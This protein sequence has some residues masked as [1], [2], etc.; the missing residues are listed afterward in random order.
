MADGLE[1][2]AESDAV[3]AL[4][5][6][7]VQHMVTDTRDLAAAFTAAAAHVAAQMPHSTTQPAGAAAAAADEAAGGEADAQG[8]SEMP[9]QQLQQR[10]AAAGSEVDADCQLALSH[11]RDSYGKLL[12]V[13]LLASLHRAGRDGP[14]QQER[15]QP[16]TAVQPAM[17]ASNQSGAELAGVAETST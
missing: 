4:I 10:A 2:P 14:E 7:Q 17:Q 16:P 11:V 3:G 15:Q 13:V 12:Y 1:W 5:R 8:D 9:Q 6:S